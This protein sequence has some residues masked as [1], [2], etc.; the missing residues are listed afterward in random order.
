MYDSKFKHKLRSHVVKA[1]QQYEDERNEKETLLTFDVS[2]ESLPFNVKAYNLILKRD[3]YNETQTL[4]YLTDKDFDHMPGYVF[5]FVEGSHGF[6]VTEGVEE[7][8]YFLARWYREQIDQS[9][10]DDS[11]SETKAKM[12]TRRRSNLVSRLRSLFEAT[13]DFLNLSMVKLN[14]LGVRYDQIHTND[15]VYRIERKEDGSYFVRFL[16]SNFENT[17]FNLDYASTSRDEYKMELL[18]LNKTF[19]TQPSIFMQFYSLFPNPYIL[20]GPRGYFRRPFGDAIKL[21]PILQRLV[22]EGNKSAMNNIR[23]LYWMKQALDRYHFAKFPDVEPMFVN[24]ILTFWNGSYRGRLEELIYLGMDAKN[25]FL[26]I[27][28]LPFR[29]N[30]KLI[31]NE[32]DKE[33]QRVLRM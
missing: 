11:R 16:L 15:V 19:F 20:H 23:G 27:D 30:K 31:R 12:H 7:T 9:E 17:S 6:I 8:V 14:E 5:S 28:E 33:L 24:G 29:D 4:R 10:P 25:I 22:K 1:F 21:I 18:V 26:A 13:F 3:F 32:L 2:F